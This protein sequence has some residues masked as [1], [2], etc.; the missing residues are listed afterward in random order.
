MKSNFVIDFELIKNLAISKAE[1][2]VPFLESLKI[3][4]IKHKSNS[5][6]REFVKFIESTKQRF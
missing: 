1:A 4:I 6:S 3:K 5:K 2:I